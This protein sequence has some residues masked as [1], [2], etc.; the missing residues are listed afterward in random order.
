MK[1][2]LRENLVQVHICSD[3]DVYSWSP[4]QTV[5]KMHSGR[6]VASVAAVRSGS[7]FRNISLQEK[8]APFR[9]IKEVTGVFDVA[10]LR[11]ATAGKSSWEENILQTG[12]CFLDIPLWQ[13]CWLELPT[14]RYLLA[15]VTW[16]KL[17][18]GTM[19]RQL[20]RLWK[21][22]KRMFQNNFLWAWWFT[23]PT[24]SNRSPLEFWKL[25]TFSLFS[26]KSR[27]QQSKR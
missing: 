18:R 16:K 10:S 12:F 27:N 22:K 2:K 7:C 5:W 13:H 4:E 3:L 19:S 24:N 21:R 23:Y 9:R 11:R 17:F 14:G 1:E 20:K 8:V 15:H 26:R 6:S 25:H